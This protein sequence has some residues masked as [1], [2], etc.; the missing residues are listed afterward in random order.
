MQYGSI[1]FIGNSAAGWVRLDPKSDKK[2][3]ILIEIYSFPLYLDIKIF[4]FSINL[5]KHACLD[6][7]GKLFCAQGG[8]VASFLILGTMGEVHFTPN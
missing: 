3:S 5:R 1:E 7:M 8:T 4:R 2:R 6:H